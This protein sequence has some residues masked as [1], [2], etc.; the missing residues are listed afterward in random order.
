MT[1]LLPLMVASSALKNVGN[2]MVEAGHASPSTAERSCGSR[3]A[4]DLDAGTGGRDAIIR[5]V[6]PGLPKSKLRARHRVVNTK[7]GRQFVSTYTPPATRTEEGVI[8][9]VA[10]EAM[11]GRAPLAGPLELKFAIWLP[12]PQSWSNKKRAAALAGAILPTTKPDWDNGGKITDSLNG[13]VWNDDSQVTDAHVWKRYSDRPRVV[14]EIRT[15]APP[16]L[17]SPNGN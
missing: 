3:R 6:V 10:A 17:L 13:I 1:E 11:A 4:A 12:I 2:G 14:I 9:M 7:D 5:F 15:A 8:R 16:G